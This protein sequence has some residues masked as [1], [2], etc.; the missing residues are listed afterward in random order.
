[1]T[2][3]SL[4]WGGTPWARDVEAEGL[5]FRGRLAYP[6]E[7]WQKL[8]TRSVSRY[9]I[10]R[11]PWTILH[12]LDPL[13]YDVL[14]QRFPEQAARHRLMPDPVEAV[15]PIQRTAAR[16]ELEIAIDGRYVGCVGVLNRHAGADMLLAGF[17]AARLAGTDRLL[18][19]GPMDDTMRK[20]VNREN[21]D[22]VR[23]GRIVTIDR[24]LS[25]GDVMRAVMA[26]DLMCVPRPFHIGSSSFVIR[27]AAA[28]RPILVSRFGWRGWAVSKFG[29]G[30]ASD[31]SDAAALSTALESAMERT[32]DWRLTPIGER[33]VRYHLADNFQAHW[34]ARLRERLQ[35]PPDK[36]LLRWET[37]FE[38]D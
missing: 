3:Q 27:S 21:G 9:L 5:Y 17:R 6:V 38:R 2:A 20:L 18:L 13:V 29:L 11:S 7:Q 8:F 1:M 34:T 31:I 14:V 23:A 10:P 12:W 4:I 26:C 30:W 24:H 36:R 37:V 32:A 35:L 15:K 22:L 28:R 19:A 33:F 16:G 25:V